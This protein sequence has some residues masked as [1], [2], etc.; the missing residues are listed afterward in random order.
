MNCGLTHRRAYGDELSLF[1]V[2]LTRDGTPANLAGKTVL[3][4]LYDQDGN[5]IIN[6][7]ATTVSLAASGHVEF[8]FTAAHYAAMIAD[9]TSPLHLVGEETFFGFFKVRET[10][11]PGTEPD[12]YPQDEIGIKVEIFNPA[13]SRTTPAP[14]ITPTN[15]LELAKA[16]RRTRTV[17][18]TVEE[19]SVRELILADQYIAGKAAPEVP[20]WGL[21]VAKTMPGS[22]TSG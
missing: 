6:G 2:Q 15:I 10:A 7:G 18:G 13:M 14:S 20:P 17:E 22:T 19:R 5:A 8:D 11:G 1:S 16:P 3:F 9:Q 21:R 12:T 4:Y